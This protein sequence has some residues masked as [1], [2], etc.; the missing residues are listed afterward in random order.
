MSCQR[1]WQGVGV[2]EKARDP[3]SR[4]A[5]SEI[6]VVVCDDVTEMRKLLRYAL[7]TD[8]RMQVIGEA[9]DGRQGAEMIAELQPDAVLLDLSMPEMDGLETIPAI[10]STAPETAII[11]FSGF[12]AERMREPALNSG[13]DMYLEKGSPLDEVIN[14]VRDVVDTRRGEGHGPGGGGDTSPPDTGLLRSWLP[15]LG[16]GFGLSLPVPPPAGA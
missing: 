6:R 1:R 16:G 7:E 15:R 3:M 5:E 8:P 12:A 9:G 11:V 14:A 13:A 10:S 2:P 4:E